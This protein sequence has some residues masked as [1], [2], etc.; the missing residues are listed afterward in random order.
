[1]TDTPCID[2]SSAC[3]GKADSATPVTKGAI[4]ASFAF[5]AIPAAGD[6]EEA[7]PRRITRFGR[8]EVRGTCEAGLRLCGRTSHAGEWKGG[9]G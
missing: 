4:I 6:S 5:H 1:M 3:Y 2:F 9:L 7:V 8:I